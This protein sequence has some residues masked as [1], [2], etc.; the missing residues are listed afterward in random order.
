MITVSFHWQFAVLQHVALT[1][2]IHRLRSN[3]VPD[4]L[5]NV[6]RHVRHHIRSLSDSRLQEARRQLGQ[7]YAGADLQDGLIHR[8]QV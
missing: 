8:L 7:L 4:R 6:P 1:S 3:Y 2:G 5:G